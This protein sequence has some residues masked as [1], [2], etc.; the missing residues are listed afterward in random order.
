MQPYTVAGQNDRSLGSHA[1][2]EAPQSLRAYPEID[3]PVLWRFE[4]I[5]LSQMD[6]VALMN[7]V[8]T[9]YVFGLSQLPRLLETLVDDYWALE[10]AGVRLSHYR[11]LYFDSENLDLYSSHLRGLA[12]RYKVRSRS[13]LDSGTSF[14]EVKRKTNNGRTI[15]ERLKTPT[16]FTQLTPEATHFVDDLAPNGARPLRATLWNEF[17]RITLVSKTRPERVTMDLHLGFQGGKG[18]TSLDSLVIAE[19]KQERPSRDAT[20]ITQLRGLG[21]R[22]TPFSKYCIGIALLFPHEKHN[23][24]KPILER[25]HRIDGGDY[26]A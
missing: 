22:P 16:F 24:F 1:E 3:L 20:F 10:V 5:T 14:L 23:R 4:P 11:T 18:R 12:E 15:K 6:A 21:I 2:R 26:Y 13:Y 19:I 25:A 7:R 8:D 9:K 17:S